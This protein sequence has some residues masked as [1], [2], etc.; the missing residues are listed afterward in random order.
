MPEQDEKDNTTEEMSAKPTITIAELD[1]SEDSAETTEAK[2][3]I[4]IAEKQGGGE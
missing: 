4:T 2:P 1:D 3:T